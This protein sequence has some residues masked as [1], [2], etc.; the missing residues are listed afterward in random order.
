MV[1][2][3]VILFV[4]LITAIIYTLLWHNMSDEGFR[5]FKIWFVFTVVITLLP[6]IFNGILSLFF[7][8][9]NVSLSN[10]LVH[11]E[12]FIVSVGIGSDAIGRVFASRTK[13]DFDITI[14][15]G[16]FIL[17][18][19]SAGLFGVFSAPLNIS[20]LNYDNVSLFSLVTFTMT[21][22]LSAICVFMSEE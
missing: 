4:I 3:L 11:G 22:L 12:L 16:C 2:F 19:I 10:V 21:I 18:V 7:V 8:E 1:T 5:R 13:R 17:V 9:S 6:I 15:G 14:V 20:N